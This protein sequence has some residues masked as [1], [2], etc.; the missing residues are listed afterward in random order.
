[1]DDIGATGGVQESG[2]PTDDNAEEMELDKI[3][4]GEEG[5]SCNASDETSSLPSS[6]SSA[7]VDF[8]DDTM[9]EEDDRPGQRHP[10]RT[11]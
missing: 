4:S 6:V 9:N 7:D 1:M 5:D 10:C 11:A 3:D 8:L 2:Y